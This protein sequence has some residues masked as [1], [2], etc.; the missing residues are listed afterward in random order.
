MILRIAAIMD[1]YHGNQNFIFFM[2]WKWFFICSQKIVN[3]IVQKKVL[4]NFWFMGGFHLSILE[5]VWILKVTDNLL[6]G[7]TQKKEPKELQDSWTKMLFNRTNLYI[8]ARCAVP[9]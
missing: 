2:F 5:S 1:G 3:F 8:F 7:K 6:L 4:E 9:R